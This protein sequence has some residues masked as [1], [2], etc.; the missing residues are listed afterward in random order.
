MLDADDVCNEAD[1][2]FNEGGSAS[3]L[4]ADDEDFKASGVKKLHATARNT[5]NSV[6][7]LPTRDAISPQLPKTL[8]SSEISPSLLLEPQFFKPKST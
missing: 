4:V 7:A 8:G 5:L 3:D 1:D 2:D 6:H